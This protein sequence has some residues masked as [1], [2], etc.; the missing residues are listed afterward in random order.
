MIPVTTSN[1]TSVKAL[2]RRFGVEW[3]GNIAT[4]FGYIANA[5]SGSNLCSF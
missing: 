4:I 2:N 5:A 1:S 3:D